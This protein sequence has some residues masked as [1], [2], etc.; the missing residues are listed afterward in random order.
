VADIPGPRS[1]FDDP[2]LRR[3]V[4]YTLGLLA[5]FRAGTY[6][7]L[8]GAD[9]GALK[10][11]VDAQAGG[12]LGFL[13][14]FSGG[15]LGRFSLFSLGAAPYV[16]AAIVA[17]LLKLGKGRRERGE[18][19]RRLTLLFALLQSFGLA[20]AFARTPGGVSAI[21]RPDGLFYASTVLTMTA[22]ALF[23]MWL[24][25]EITESGIG[26]GALLIVFAG[27]VAHSLTG[28]GELFRL[29]RVED[30][31]M[32]SALAITAALLAFVLATIWVETAQ[33]KLTVYYAKRVVGR[34]M[35]GGSSSALPL[36]LEQSGIVAAVSAA[37]LAASLAALALAAAGLFP[38]SGGE[39]AGWLARGSWVGDAID[40]ALILLLCAYSGSKTVDPEELADQLKKSGGSIPGI[41]P[42]DS[43]ARHLQWIRDRIGFDGAVF[44]AALAVLPD[45]LR[46]LLRLPFFF[47]GLPLLV[48]V[49]VSLDA[50]GR[51]EGFGIR[52]A[53]AKFL[54]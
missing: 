38:H 33:R 31:G 53:Y 48:I 23:V 27:L 51:V 9:A 7:P 54:K 52:R 45:V 14:A 34:R 18:A 10:S 47:D 42:G 4:F 11:F 19:A 21:P 13:D 22:G 28:A 17:G 8:P 44:V 15:A 40:A 50:M 3:R 35:Y 16:N 5:V 20:L 2:D 32:S 41:R 1:N 37:V 30:L 46:R 6:V 12:L 36:K 26:G 25:E 43:T 29:V 39:F 24:C 49:G